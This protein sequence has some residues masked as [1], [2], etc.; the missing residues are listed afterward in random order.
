MDAGNEVYG[1]EATLPL[2]HSPGTIMHAMHQAWPLHCT[3]RKQSSLLYLIGPFL[4]E[5]KCQKSFSAHLRILKR[6]RV[7]I[8]ES[9]RLLVPS[10]DFLTT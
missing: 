4:L 5:Q 10:D 3:G 9:L 1:I 8:M 2:L 6:P 7:I